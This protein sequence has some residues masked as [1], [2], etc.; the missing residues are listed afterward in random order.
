MKK[1]EY[2]RDGRSPTPS[3]DVVSRTMSSNRGKDTGPEVILRRRLREEG[4]GGYRLHWH[5][6][7]RPDIC[8]PGRRIAIFVNGCFWHRCPICNLPFPKNNTEFWKNKFE[9]NIERDDRKTEELTD[10]GWNVI[11]VWECE[12][13]DC[14]DEVV[15]R[16]KD[17]M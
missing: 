2:V 10:L 13:K 15:A 7:G 12:I 11:I 1:G 4:L 3:S 17:L 14:L 6:P 8:Y 5:I 9:R 16:I